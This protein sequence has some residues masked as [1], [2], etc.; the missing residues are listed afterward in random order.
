MKKRRLS[1][2]SCNSRINFQSVS[3]SMK[4]SLALCVSSVG[5]CVVYYNIIGY[6]EC[7]T[8]CRF[9]FSG[10]AENTRSYTEVKLVNFCFSPS[11]CNLSIQGLVF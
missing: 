6:T 1:E 5:L 7:H 2:K 3:Y 9:S 8:A 4:T 11:I 10:G